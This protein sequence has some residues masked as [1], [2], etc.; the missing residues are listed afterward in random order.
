MSSNLTLVLKLFLPTLWI[1]FFSTFTIALF[2]TD[3]EDLPFLTSPYFKY[4]FLVIFLIFLTLLYITFLKLKRIE[5]GPE[6]YYVSNY[7]RTFRL[8]YDDI[9]NINSI[10][11]GRFRWVTFYLKAKGSFGKKIT[12]LINKQLFEI[13]LAEH[14][15]VNQKFP[16]LSNITGLQ[17]E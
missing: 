7:L 10:N 5:M 4:P 17:S 12:F 16:I 2:I 13:F 11:L 6:C 1:V 3:E 14:K 9:E 8:I 15:E